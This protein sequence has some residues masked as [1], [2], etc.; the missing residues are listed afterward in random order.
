MS[1][2]NSLTGE[3]NQF[4]NLTINE[5][6]PNTGLFNILY[7]NIKLS[8]IIVIFSFIAFILNLICIIVFKHVFSFKVKYNIYL[9]FGPITDCI[10]SILFQFAYLSIDFIDDYDFICYL[11]TYFVNPLGYTCYCLSLIISL[12]I[13]I[14]R[15]VKFF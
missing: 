1:N 7:S 6:R 2:G 11:Y 12:V 9:L 10:C 5:T 13:S 8:R 3:L 14:D 4:L 15:L